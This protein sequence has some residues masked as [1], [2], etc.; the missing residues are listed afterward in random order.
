MSDPIT[1]KNKAKSD[2]NALRIE[3]DAEWVNR[4]TGLR[5]EKEAAERW[6]REPNYD[7]VISIN[8]D[9]YNK[10][11]AKYLIQELGTEHGVIA[12]SFMVDCFMS[13]EEGLRYAETL[14]KFVKQIREV[15]SNI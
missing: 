11:L 12:H 6:D 1:T 9:K 2:I 5:N 15:N 8:Y 13:V 14:V 4:E 7:G 3:Y 10:L